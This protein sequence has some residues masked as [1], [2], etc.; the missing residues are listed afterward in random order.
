MSYARMHDHVVLT[1]DLDFGTVLAATGGGKPSVVR[2]R[3]DD[4]SPDTI[5]DQI[6]AALRQM[7][8]DLAAGALLSVG[9]SRTRL[10]L[11]PLLPRAE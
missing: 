6:I 1:H 11:L 10:R 8:L 2:V 9:P 4:V 5:E 7:A 3:C